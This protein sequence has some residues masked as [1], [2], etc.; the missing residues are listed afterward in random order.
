MRSVQP[1]KIAAADSRVATEGRL[2]KM[3]HTPGRKL[4]KAELARALRSAGRTVA[5][6][7]FALKVS[8]ETVKEALGISWIDSTNKQEGGAT[9]E[10][11]AVVR[12][13]LIQARGALRLDAMVDDRGE[14]FGTT[15]VALEAIEKALSA[16]SEAEGA[17]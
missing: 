4:T 17:K 12:E 16:I 2:T 13:G 8:P 14:F 15:E 3:A 10:F 7:A 6:I 5:E 9:A 1:N 11:F